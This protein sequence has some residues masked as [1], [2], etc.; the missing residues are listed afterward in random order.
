MGYVTGYFPR[1]AAG[2]PLRRGSL[3]YPELL[4][5][6]RQ[7][8]SCRD[9]AMRNV[10]S[11][12]HEVTTYSAYGGHEP[13]LIVPEVSA[14]A[15]RVDVITIGINPRWTKQADVPC[16][17]IPRGQL[18][19]PKTF[20]KYKEMI[21]SG[22]PVGIGV[23]HVELVQCGT[24]SGKDVSEIITLCRNRF[25]DKVILALRPKVIIPIGKWASEHLYWYNTF[26]GKSGTRWEGIRRRHATIERAKFGDHECNLVFVLQPSSYVS[27]DK[28]NA[29]RDAIAQ[30][31][32]EQG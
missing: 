27:M 22:L 20:D 6:E 5:M 30:A 3:M 24:P 9:E 16:Q 14:L 31:H 18:Y 13:Q 26:P 32:H 1:E 19:G 7:V 12:C 4:K 25:F 11:K 29:A 2:F 17:G 10:A 15:S 8:R 28:R 21:L 23:A